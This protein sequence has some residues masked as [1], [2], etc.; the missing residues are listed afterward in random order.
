MKN[1][2][3]ISL[4]AAIAVAGLTSTAS[5][6]SLEEAIKG[7]DISGAISYTMEKLGKSTEE[8]QHDIDI[9]ATLKSTINDNITA[10]IR[11][12]ESNDD[13][14]DNI[15]TTTTTLTGDFDNNTTSADQSFTAENTTGSQNSTSVNMEID[16]AYFTYAND[17]LTSSFGLIGAPLTDGGQ[18]DGINVS[19]S[20]GTVTAVG[21]Y[22]YNSGAKKTQDV[23]F[24]GAV[25]SAGTVGYNLTYAS[26]MES[27][28]DAASKSASFLHANLNTKVAM[29]K[30]NFDYSTGDALTKDQSQMKLSANVPLGAV[31]LDVAYAVNGSDGGSTLIDGSDVAKSNITMGATDLSDAIA[32]GA[33][34]M[35]VAAST[36]LG[37]GTA[38]LAY[39]AISSDTATEEEKT[40]KL[41]YTMALSSNF[42][43][44]ANYEDYDLS[45]NESACLD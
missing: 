19:K 5:A 8:A 28:A 13:D 23:A 31:T 33:S 15:K 21:G 18:G 4:V 16:R 25:G 35:Y 30:I 45:A 17:G 34:A 9:R 42:K 6:K 3:K 1:T 41:N 14:K 38:T 11:F 27:D 44:F 36:K 40:M 39:A 24:L 12:D 43:V 22:L 26:L 10:N 37:S 7:T 29:A 20:F 2:I 32:D